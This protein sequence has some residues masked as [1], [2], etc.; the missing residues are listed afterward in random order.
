MLLVLRALFAMKLIYP[1]PAPPATVKQQL[2]L[3]VSRRKVFVGHKVTTFGK[4]G[5]HFLEIVLLGQ[6]F[7]C[8]PLS[9]WSRVVFISETLLDLH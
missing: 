8:H 9:L 5:S 2:A 1:Y 3:D 6:Q 4:Q 7:G